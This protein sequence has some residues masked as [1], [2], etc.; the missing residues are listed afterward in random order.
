MVSRGAIVAVVATLLLAVGPA[1]ARAGG[2][3]ALV[4]QAGTP[5]GAVDPSEV[6]G[7]YRLDE[8]RWAVPLRA[9]RPQ[10]LTPELLAAADS[11]PVAAP[12]GAALPDALLSGYVGIRPGSQM[13]YPSGCTMN[14][15]FGS[16]DSY[17]IGTGGH[18]AKVGEQV[19][20]LTIAPGTP[21]AP[22]NLVLVTIGA[23]EI[24]RNGGIGEDYALVSIKPQLQSWVFPTIA[25]VGGPCG[26]YTGQGLT[27]V[28][29]PLS[30]LVTGA[31]PIE[32]G[33]TIFHYGHGLGI[34]TGGTARAGAAL[35]W[36]D[37]AYYWAGAVVYG[38]SGSAARV[39]T[40]AAAGNV[41]HLV[42]D[43]RYPGAYHAGT[44]ITR[45]GTPVN[46]PYCP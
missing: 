20:L 44:R 9:S 31:N 23:V 22:E 28:P 16:P 43:L 24:S 25:Q 8:H 5:V 10:W 38:D 42:V 18:C 30:L 4:P 34:G 35:Y 7:A 13:V 33:E 41:T 14:F 46:S 37:S 27:S 39:G 6:A 19:T 17:T 12:A 15:V 26:S 32:A 1:S 2:A 21:P 3:E 11:G 29:N 45:I 40:M 36:T